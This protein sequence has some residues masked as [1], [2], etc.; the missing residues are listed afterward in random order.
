M[1]RH[2]SGIGPRTASELV[3]G[4]NIR[5]SR[6]NPPCL[7]LRSSPAQPPVRHPPR[8]RRSPHPGRATRVRTCSYSHTQ[9]P[10]QVRNRFGKVLPRAG[11]RGMCCGE[12]KSRRAQK[13]EGDHAIMPDKVPYSAVSRS[14]KKA[15]A[16][17]G[18]QQQLAIPIERNLPTNQLST[19]TIG[20]HYGIPLEL[21]IYI[22]ENKSNT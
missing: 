7:L 19:K 16:L 18:R 15:Q 8:Y 1:P 5:I 6:I 20:T 12:I 13:A 4:A 17:R 14:K 3:I 11:G 21:V 22:D 10:G 2:H 9:R